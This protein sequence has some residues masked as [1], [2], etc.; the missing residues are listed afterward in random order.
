MWFSIRVRHTH[1]THPRRHD[2]VDPAPQ[3]LTAV[4]ENLETGQFCFARAT[5]DGMIRIAILGVPER[6]RVLPSSDAS[7]GIFVRIFILTSIVGVVGQI[8]V[9]LRFLV[10][11]T[12]IYMLEDLLR[13]VTAA[14]FQ[15]SL[16]SL[17]ASCLFSTSWIR[18]HA[19]FMPGNQ[20]EK[21]GCSFSLELGERIRVARMARVVLVDGKSVHYLGC[22]VHI[23]TRSLMVSVILDPN[24]RHDM[25]TI[26][27]TDFSRHVNQTTYAACKPQKNNCSDEDTE[28]FYRALHMFQH[29]LKDVWRWAPR[30]V[31]TA[32]PW[33]STS[34]LSDETLAMA[35]LLRVDT[36][37]LTSILKEHPEERMK[38]LYLMAGNLQESVG[39]PGNFAFPS[40]LRFVQL[41]MARSKLPGNIHW[42][43]PLPSNAA[44]CGW[45]GSKFPGMKA[46]L[47]SWNML[48]DG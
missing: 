43:K 22:N 5:F 29:D 14:S 28:T 7:H 2:R 37:S 18:R 31:A 11:C 4:S 1:Q 44:S 27:E 38:Y 41:Q 8:T 17:R 9:N 24:I 47:R 45:G 48:V 3:L 30:L 33:R 6:S 34:R 42:D 46:V 19:I 12:V 23:E 21:V 20:L 36:M 32:L 26:E 13:A 35:A 40:S 15:F 16:C 25:D 39:C 10:K